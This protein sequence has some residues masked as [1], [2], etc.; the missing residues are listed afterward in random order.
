METASN[1]ITLN[2]NSDEKVTL[3]GIIE[4]IEDMSPNFHEEWDALANLRVH[5]PEKEFSTSVFHAFLPNNPVAIGEC[6]QVEETGVLELLRQLN[7][8]P[9]LDMHIDIG[10]SSGLWATLLAYNDQQA[11][12][13]FRIH[14]EFALTDGWFTPSHFAGDLIID[15]TKEDVVYFRLHVPEGKWFDVNWKKYKDD[16]DFVY[17]TAA[18]VCPQIELYGGK[19]DLL[20]DIEYNTFITQEKAE[21]ILLQQFYKSN[22]IEWIP[23]G[24]AYETAQ[25]EQKP[26][27]VLSID[28]PLD[29]EAC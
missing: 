18:G 10:D 12:V 21:H 17:S 13:V 28:G 1:N 22:Q 4:P 3:K 29:D 7:P 5:E 16:S 6:W 2:L 24:E 26:I 9:N 25:A 27:H 23:F 15:Q 19:Q 14:A 20:K 11:H 8:E